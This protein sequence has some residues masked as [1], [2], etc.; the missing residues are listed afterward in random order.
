MAAGATRMQTAE[1]VSHLEE[2]VEWDPH[3]PPLRCQLTVVL[4]QLGRKADA[5][6][7]VNRAEA[8]APNDPRVARVKASVLGR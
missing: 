4:N 5:L 8:L 1:A 7:A 3:S 2:A 6:E